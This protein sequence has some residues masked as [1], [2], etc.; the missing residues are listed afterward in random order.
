VPRRSCRRGRATP[1]PRSPSV[2]VSPRG[3]RCRS[4]ESG[5]SSEVLTALRSGRGQVVRVVFSTADRGGQ[6]AGVRAAGGERASLSHAG[7]ALSSPA[8]RSRAGSSSESPGWRWLS[9]DASHPWNY[10]SWTFP[11]DPRFRDRAGPI[12][13]LYEGRWEGELLEPG[14]FVV[15]ADDKPSIQARARKDPSEPAKPGG[16]GQLR[17]LLAN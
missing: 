17:A 12:L 4:G 14:D 11:R 3:C 8:K 5:S 15:C 2:W 7:Q 16:D 1:R 9:A 6:G 10:R 13:D